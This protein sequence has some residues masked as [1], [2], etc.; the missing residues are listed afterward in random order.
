MPLFNIITTKEIVRGVVLG[1]IIALTL[2][3]INKYYL[4]GKDDA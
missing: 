3:A 1:I 2:W 4:K